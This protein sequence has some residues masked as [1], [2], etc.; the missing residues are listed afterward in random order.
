MPS[1]NAPQEKTTLHPR[2]KNRERYNLDALIAAVPELAAHVKP[3]KFGDASVDFA[4]PDAVRLLNRALLK[5]YYAIEHWDF[6]AENLTPPIPGRADYIHYL[7]DLLK[8]SNFGRMP[9]GEKITVVD[10]G[11]GASC[12]YPMLAVAEYGFTVIG[13]DIEPKSVTSAQAI[14]DTN[15]VLQNKITL[16]L[17]ANARHIFTGIIAEGEKADVTLCNPPFHATAA[18]AQKGTQRKVSALSG[19]R[20]KDAGL[21][22]AG[23]SNELVYNGGEHGFI[24][25]MISES[26]RFANQCFWF[27]TLVSKQSNLKGI[28]K[29]LDALKATQ[30][31]TI[32]MGTGNKSTRIVAWSF[33]T[34]EQQK[35]WRENRWR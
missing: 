10:I 32:S 31:K 8:E 2:N 16:R 21:N 26:K 17:Q 27:T 20:V 7:A 12:I 13:S 34:P 14:I 11:T 28:Y 23:V 1:D 18:E 4:N 35:T 24:H 15:A 30:V 6:P 5:H 19:K 33:L 22:F 29:A 25:N 3:N 9:S